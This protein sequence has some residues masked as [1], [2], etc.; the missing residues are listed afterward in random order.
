MN[1]VFEENKARQRQTSAQLQALAVLLT[2]RVSNRAHFWAQI[3]NTAIDYRINDNGIE[4]IIMNQTKP[5]FALG[6]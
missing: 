5:S 2:I 1:T 4:L 3:L 6:W